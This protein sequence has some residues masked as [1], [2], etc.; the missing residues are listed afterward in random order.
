MSIKVRDILTLRIF[1]NAVLLTNKDTTKRIIKSVSVSD[2]PIYE[3]LLEQSI[4]MKGDFYLSTLNL[5]HN[6]SKALK[7]AIEVMI[8]AESSGLCITNEF[9]ST[10]PESIIELCNNNGFP[11]I[12]IDK[13]IPYSKIIRE[14]T[15]TIISHQSDLIKINTVNELINGNSK[16]NDKL[17]LIHKLNSNFK[18]FYKAYYVTD[19]NSIHYNTFIQS[20][21]EHKSWFSIP[22]LQG[23]LAVIS[24]NEEDAIKIDKRYNEYTHYYIQQAKELG[25]CVIGIS[26]KHKGII[27]IDQAMREAIFATKS[28]PYTSQK[29]LFYDQ[30]GSIRLLIALKN[31][32]ELLNYYELTID[33]I[34]QYDKLYN[35]SLFDTL[36]YYVKNDGDYKQ[37]AIDLNQHENTIRYRINKAKSIL[38][39]EG[40]TIQF[41]ETI[42]LGLKAYDIINN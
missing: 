24:F 39:L 15:E 22:Y 36:R 3:E 2:C 31:H 5:Y 27:N 14:I 13:N 38:S 37:T 10:I 28:S 7:A 34:I 20:I 19:M 32:R 33:K 29:I 30:L 41:H 23:I 1:D 17:R 9:F 18:Q 21:N 42:S 40:N 12:R 11:I 4:F 6:N 16:G 35:L 26:S 8:K 25:D